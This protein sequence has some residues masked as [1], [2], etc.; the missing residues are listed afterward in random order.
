MKNTDLSLRLTSELCLEQAIKEAG[1]EN[2]A[3]VS[4]L[5]VCGLLTDDDFGYIRVNMANTLKELDMNNAVIEEN[6][7]R[8][9]A[10]ERCTG[11]I[12][13]LIPE[14]V[15]NISH[16][17]FLG[18]A[19]LTWVNIP[20]TVATISGSAFYDCNKLAFVEVAPNNAEYSSVD[21][22]LFDKSKK[23][24][25]FC[26]KGIQGEYIVPD[27][28]TSIG[29]HAFEECTGLTAVHIP[30]GV[31]SI[32]GKAFFRCTGITAITLPDSVIAIGNRA[33]GKC[34][35]L[36]HIEAVAGNSECGALLSKSK[37]TLITCPEGKTG[38]FTIPKGVVAIG[39]RAFEDC[40]K[41]TRIIIPEGVLSIGNK[42]FAGCA[43]L[44]TLI[45]P[46]SVEKVAK[47]AF[48]DC[49]ATR[50]VFADG[51]G[52]LVDTPQKWFNM[53]LKELLNRCDFKDIAPHFKRFY[54]EQATVM[55]RFKEA[56][57]VLR[58]LEPKLN[59]DYPSYQA[60]K[61]TRCYNDDNEK[62]DDNGDYYIHATC[63]GDFWVSDLAKEIVVADDLSLTDAEIAAHCLW[64]MT[65]FGN[66]YNVDE[67]EK[68]RSRLL[69]E[70]DTSNPYTVAAE[71][72][73][74]KLRSNYL[75]KQY[76]EAVEG[77]ISI[78]SEEWLKQKK[79]MGEKRWK[80]YR[81]A[82]YLPK[83]IEPQTCRNR[84]KRMRDHRMEKRIKKLE[85][86]AK[87]EDA[88]RRLTA[89]TKSFKREELK[90]IFDT[91]QITENRYQSRVYDINQRTDYL[92]E[93]FENYVLED[94]SKFTHFL[95]MFRTSS[96]YPLTQ[97]ETE[98]LQKFFIEFLPTNVN[99]RFGYGNDEN[100]DTEIYLMLLGNY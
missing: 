75:P 17:A 28:V 48:D 12:S 18:C 56:F 8:D 21:G 51:I 58:H 93:L 96:E 68:K 82:K 50:K 97:E 95:L 99:I 85:R 36:V 35:N 60:I 23:S 1:I 5:T 52:E 38:T 40:A 16:C 73:D 34:T 90:Y 44:E 15:T 83:D 59:P 25:I 11:L 77:T 41:L 100:L 2:P 65:F 81:S 13:V 14:G 27:G 92:I 4:K 30:H 22:A 64:E 46:A 62:I 54:P 55:Y 29:E 61:L 69:G 26:P 86:M 88:I 32:G 76:K 42:A 39:E 9:S 47:D 37:K 91:A 10:L 74:N 45:I 31:K 53:T 70:T 20:S 33:F 43:E 79:E 49:P 24:M 87:V 57:D 80:N 3:C 84:P 19:E 72:L 66:P 67:H 63:G 98:V 71:K 6:I 89:N 7:I 94:F 78:T